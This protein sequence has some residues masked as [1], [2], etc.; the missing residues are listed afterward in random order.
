MGERGADG[1]WHETG[2]Y[3]HLALMEGNLTVLAG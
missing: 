2:L 3:A 1:N